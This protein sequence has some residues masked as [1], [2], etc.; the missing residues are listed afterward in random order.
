MRDD[1]ESDD[2]QSDVDIGNITSDTS[3]YASSDN[4][5]KNMKDEEHKE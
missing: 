2:D 3:S 5:D 4:E 1:N